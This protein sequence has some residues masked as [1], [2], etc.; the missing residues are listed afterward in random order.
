[1]QNIKLQIILLQVVILMVSWNALP[2]SAYYSYGAR[3]VG[4]GNA[5]TGMTNDASIFYW[6]PGALVVLPGWVVE[7]QYGRDALYAED[8]KATMESMKRWHEEGEGSESKLA[9]GMKELASKDWLFRGGEAMSFVIANNH[10]AMFF[11]QQQI[12]Y[13]QYD[14]SNL[15]AE[16]S[17][18]ETDEWRYSL[19][20]VDLQ[21]YGVSFTMLGGDSGFSMGVSGKYIRAKTFYSSPLFTEI[22]NVD[23]DDMIE[24]VES[25]DTTTVSRWS[26]DAGIVMVFGPNRLGISGRNL[27]RYSIEVTE[28]T[29]I[30]IKPEYRIGYAFQPT[31]RFVFCMDYSIGKER[32]LLGNRLNAK[33]LATGFEGFFGAKRRLVLRG[34]VSMPME[35]DAPMVLSVGS[36]LV[37]DTAIFDVG[38]AF[39]RDHDSR[40]LWF[41][42]RFMF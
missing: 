25:G 15:A 36:G 30:T 8:V 14:R 17:S 21:E 18:G 41:G 40:K 2:V 39:D 19:P 4:M 22:T 9:R 37:F 33:E 38:Y 16:Q 3:A 35:G 34:G 10:M 5:F 12:Y 26:W 11:N 13:A 20:G 6:N 28:D 27:N 42:L 24:L 32:D 23:L 1:M 7:L 31:D 29:S